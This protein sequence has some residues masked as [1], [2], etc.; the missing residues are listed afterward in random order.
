MPGKFTITL[1]AAALACAMLLG[2]CR[3]M[4][5]DF[6]TTP[7]DPPR[8]EAIAELPENQGRDLAYPYPRD[9]A[10]EISPLPV[11]GTDPDPAETLA[12]VEAVV[13]AMAG[14]EI[15][16][17]NRERL[18]IEVVASTPL[19]KFKDDVVVEIR[20]SAVSEEAAADPEGGQAKETGPEP[21]TVALEI[22]MRSKSRVGRFDFGA[23][24]KRV[25]LFFDR[26]NSAFGE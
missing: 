22:H 19:L 18:K 3:S 9:E 12:T 26:L 4:R 5:N 7:G 8:F 17:V 23:N 11:P 25:A 20:R 24:R 13:G 6:T 15:V 16:A 1:I 14:W 21:A 2:S 10:P